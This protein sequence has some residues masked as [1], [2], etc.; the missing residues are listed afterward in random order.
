MTGKFELQRLQVL[1]QV[2]RIDLEWKSP[3]R[4]ATP[5]LAIYAPGLPC[6]DPD[7]HRDTAATLNYGYLI[8]IHEREGFVGRTCYE[9]YRPQ[10]DLAPWETALTN[11]HYVAGT[12]LR[13]DWRSTTLRRYWAWVPAL[14]L[15]W[16]VEPHKAFLLG[17]LQRLTT[18]KQP[19]T[20]NQEATVRAM[21]RERGGIMRYPDDRW[22]EELAV[23]V[24][25]LRARRDLA[26][27]LGQL[28]TL[29]LSAE[30][31]ETVENL[32]MRNM[33]WERG[34]M[35][36]LS[37]RQVSII[38]ALEAQHLEERLVRN[39]NLAAELAEDEGCQ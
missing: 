9:A 3:L 11:R 33:A 26:F 12:G 29:D 25:V 31:L 5:E 38:R 10:V 28:L 34:H 21:L 15:L 16:Q 37:S 27:R 22:V 1:A 19:L 32:R 39:W 14:A 13:P 20:A 30:D 4:A 24:M 36:S 7:G 6:A 23:H 18:G 2:Q 8:H 35:Q 17:Y